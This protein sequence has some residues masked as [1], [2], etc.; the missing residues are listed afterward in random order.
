MK[1]YDLHIRPKNPE[2]AGKIIK[3]AEKLKWKGICLVEYFNDLNNF[4]KFRENVLNLKKDA[5]IEIFIGAEIKGKNRNEI[6]K[7]AQKSMNYADIIFACGSFDINR[8]FAE[9]WGIDVLA[10]PEAQVQKDFMDQKNSGIDHIIANLLFEHKTAVEINFSN[11][12][13]TYGL[14]RAQVM[15]RMS[16]N[17]KLARKYNCLSILASDASDMWGMRAPREFIAVG[18]TLGMTEHEA[19]SSIT[20]N[21][22]KIIQKS[23]DRGSPDVI[24]SGLEVL[25]WGEQERQ[26]K[27]MFGWY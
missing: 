14:V 18:K 15:G 23:L 21:P 19:K 3:I 17:I 27:K 12:L 9:V 6:Q 7:N 20:T 11:I 1:A 16:Q 24:L 4:K 2:E 26:E 25:K 8:E 13:N 22:E 5:G 10:H